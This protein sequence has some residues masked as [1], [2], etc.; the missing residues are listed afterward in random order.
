M[1]RRTPRRVIA[2]VIPPSA[3]ACAPGAPLCSSPAVLDQLERHDADDPVDHR[4]GQKRR[5]LQPDR[6]VSRP[7]P[8]APES[9]TRARWSPPT[10]ITNRGSGCDTM[11]CAPSTPTRKPDQRLGESADPDD[12]TGQRILH[13]AADAAGHQPDDR[14]ERQA[15]VDHR[16]Q[17]QVDRVAPPCDSPASVVCSASATASA[18]STPPSSLSRPRQAR[19]ASRRRGAPRRH[20]HDQH[21]FDAGKVDRRTHRDHP[22]QSRPGR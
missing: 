1:R 15:D 4:L 7:S 6:R 11:N 20:H 16:H 5:I 19:P 18:R 10:N 14:A 22:V 12:P 17:H 8:P 13:Q 2:A 3:H 21:L 9:T